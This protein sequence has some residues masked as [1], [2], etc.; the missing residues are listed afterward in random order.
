MLGASVHFQTLVVLDPPTV[1]SMLR[2]VLPH[3]FAFGVCFASVLRSLSDAGCARSS[4][5]L[6]AVEVCVSPH[7]S[8]SFLVS[9]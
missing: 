6:A 8:R 7:V 9:V 5:W 3:L 2:S 1:F 4:H